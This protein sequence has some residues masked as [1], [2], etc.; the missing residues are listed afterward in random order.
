MGTSILANLCQARGK[1]L[2]RNKL[3]SALMLLGGASLV[4]MI[5]H[6][7]LLLISRNSV[8]SGDGYSQK[9]RTCSP[10]L[11]KKEAAYSC[12]ETETKTD[13]W[14]G[15]KALVEVPSVLPSLSPSRPAVHS[16]E[17]SLSQS[18]TKRS[19]RLESPTSIPTH[20]T[21]MPSQVPFKT[22]LPTVAETD[23]PTSSPTH[24]SFYPGL[25]SEQQNKLLLSKG[26]SARIIA[27]SGKKVSYDIVNGQ[28]NDRSELACHLHPDFGAVFKDERTWNS[29]GWIYVSNSEDRAT[30]KGGVGAFTFNPKGDLIDY[31][32]ILNDTTANCGGG[33]T[34]WGAWISC[35][36]T[37][38]GQLYQ[39][40]PTGLRKPNVIT[41]GRDGGRFESF[42]Y[43]SE[44]SE[45]LAQFFVTEDIENGALRRF[46]PDSV[47]WDDPWNILLG[48]GT[49]TYLVLNPE[50]G[51]FSWTEDKRIGEESASN[52]FPF[53][54]GIDCADGFLYFISKSLKKLYVLSLRDSTYISQTT[55][56]GA[57][58]GQPDQVKRLLK[59]RDELLFFTE[60]G[61]NRPGIHARDSKGHFFTVLEGIEGDESTGLAFSPDGKHLYFAMQ[62]AGL[63]YDVTRNDGL[64]FH[65]TTVNIKYHSFPRQDIL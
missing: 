60:D 42:A 47:D 41:L 52:H 16:T 61:G 18:P 45:A 23:A 19:S 33:K 56:H 62:D 55:Q 59:S 30:G 22:V 13:G 34:P 31:R 27:Q 25:L 51:T 29:G 9:I 43:H 12:N 7:S 14:Q 5:V 53:S 65:G 20:P 40:D 35:E 39:V 38:G 4:I 11:S 36:E 24:I 28:G 63:I 26:L 58:D 46:I 8:A 64:A 54:E 44:S 21:H 6:V 49:T 3:M 17:S 32:R 50:L 57:F 48:S 37:Q 10:E 15:E 2:T 1:E